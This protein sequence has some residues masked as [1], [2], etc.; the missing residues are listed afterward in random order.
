MDRKEANQPVVQEIRGRDKV[1]E[2]ACSEVQTMNEQINEILKGNESELL[3]LILT[4]SA[5]VYAYMA[6][7]LGKT[8]FSFDPTWWRVTNALNQALNAVLPSYVPLKRIDIEKAKRWLP[9]AA[10]QASGLR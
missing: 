10:F 9:E 5:P 6:E 2:K 1:Y 4:M 7:K 3:F 8:D